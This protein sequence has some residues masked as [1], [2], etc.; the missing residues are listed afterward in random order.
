MHP[1]NPA[2]AHVCTTALAPF[3]Q[4]QALTQRRFNTRRVTV[5]NLPA[6]ALVGRALALVAL[7]LPCGQKALAVPAPQ[8]A[9]KLVHLS[10]AGPFTVG[11]GLVQLNDE[12]GTHWLGS[13]V[14]FFTP[15]PPQSGAVAQQQA[16]RE[17]EQRDRGVLE[18]FKHRHPVLFNLAFAAIAFLAGF[19]ITGGFGGG[20]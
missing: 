6:L 13:V 2:C 19:Y 20:K 3:S 7:A 9:D 8:A 12:P 18:Q 17:S 10:A 16:Q 1:T 5:K 11:A 4:P 15:V 14:E